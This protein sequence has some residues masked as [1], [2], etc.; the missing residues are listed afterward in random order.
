MCIYLVLWKLSESLGKIV[1]Y[2]LCLFDVFLLGI[3][4]LLVSK[5]SLILFCSVFCLSGV[6]RSL[7]IFRVVHWVGGGVHA[8]GWGVCMA[9]ENLWPRIPR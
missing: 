9:G 6:S 8:G 2:L 5:L 7:E 3:L 1:N 4:A